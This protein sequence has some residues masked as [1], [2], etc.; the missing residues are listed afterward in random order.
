MRRGTVAVLGVAGVLW[1]LAAVALGLVAVGYYGPVEY[2]EVQVPHTALTL[3]LDD[4]IRSMR[5]TKQA[6][7]D[8]GDYLEN[9]HTTNPNA[10]E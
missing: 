1:I 8:L 6:L 7:Q 5:D 9:G 2:D 3:A 10:G 4:L